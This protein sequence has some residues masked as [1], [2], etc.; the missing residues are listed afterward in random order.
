MIKW[1]QFNVFISFDRCLYL[2]TLIWSNVSN[3]AIFS[4][5]PAS[6]VLSSCYLFL[7]SVCVCFRLHNMSDRLFL[8]TPLYNISY[9]VCFLTVTLTTYLLFC[10]HF[11]TVHNSVSS[12]LAVVSTQ[13]HNFILSCS[14]LH[15]PTLQTVLNY[16]DWLNIYLL[17]G[18]IE[19]KDKNLTLK[20]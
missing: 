10:L 3:A 2:D 5:T 9:N 17:L 19:Q 18:Q 6:G 11:T 14:L 1:V 13:K 7:V 20:G 4:T 15:A 12:I 16:N 8:S